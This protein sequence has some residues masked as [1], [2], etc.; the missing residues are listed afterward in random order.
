VFEVEALR[1]AGRL[2]DFQSGA[3]TTCEAPHLPAQLGAEAS[4][5]REKHSDRLRASPC[6]R[7]LPAAAETCRGRYTG[8]QETSAV[9]LESIHAANEPGGGEGGQLSWTSLWH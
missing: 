5:C 7:D 8:G 3:L 4:T 2:R 9:V 6:Q 1:P